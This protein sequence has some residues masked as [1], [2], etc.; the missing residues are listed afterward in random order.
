MK[1]YI[2]IFLSIILTHSCSDLVED[3]NNDPNNQ[4][5]SAYQTIL[6][7]A[8]VGNILL[9]TGE[10]ARRAC[11]FAGQYTGIDR[12]HL[13]YSQYSVTTSDFNALWNDGY[14][15]ALRN[16]IITEEAANNENIG[17]VT[18]GITQ[19]LQAQSFGTLTWVTRS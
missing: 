9:Q 18:I 12:Q 16:A 15:D 6:T 17:P 19:V 2:L 8:E 7:G 13:G 10:N 5:E 1:S 14:V 11:I 4:T 3:L